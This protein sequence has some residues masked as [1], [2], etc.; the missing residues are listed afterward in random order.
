MH[1]FGHRRPWESLAATRRGLPE[2]YGAQPPP[3]IRP[4]SLLRVRA[5]TC[6]LHTPSG[7]MRAAGLCVLPAGGSPSCRI[8]PHRGRNMCA[9][10]GSMGRLKMRVRSL[11][12]RGKLCCWHRRRS[13]GH[14]DLRRAPRGDA[15]SRRLSPCQARA[16]RVSRGPP[17]AGLVP[18]FPL[19]CHPR[20][21]RLVGLNGANP[22]P[23]AG[24][25]E[26]GSRGASR[27]RCA[28]GAAGSGE[29][30]GPRAE[31]RAGR[32]MGPAAGAPE[33]PRESRPGQGRGL[34]GRHCPQRCPPAVTRSRDRTGG[35]FPG[36]LRASRAGARRAAAGRRL[37]AREPPRQEESA[38]GRAGG[39]RRASCPQAARPHAPRRAEP[40][41]AALPRGAR[42]GPRRGEA[43]RAA[44]AAAAGGR[45]R[46]PPASAR[47]GTARLGTARHGSARRGTAW[48][49]S[50]RRGAVPLGSARRGSD[51]SRP[52]KQVAPAALRSRGWRV[53]AA[54]SLPR[55]RGALHTASF[56]GARSL[57]DDEIML[58]CLELLSIPWILLA[59]DA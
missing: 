21:A 45:L 42:A 50:A 14:A 43:G 1:L 12:D 32:G 13:E 23:P 19:R 38:G 8:D 34:G 37:T 28:R 55:R 2:G 16:S 31:P 35:G 33:L 4:C 5:G 54:R 47:H 41:R 24:E 52:F 20:V 59:H 30:R 29:Q 44:A 11:D 53:G 22:P 25:T 39:G 17:G 49:G 15:R 46:A 10:H 57:F 27:R 9:M 7:V 48:H 18:A 40:R 58:T 36:G 3:H 56:S 51:G 26:A 6:A